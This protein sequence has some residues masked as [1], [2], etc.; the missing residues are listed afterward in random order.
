ML[1]GLN[2]QC[3]CSVLARQQ[4]RF[5][6]R[7]TRMESRQALFM[8]G[9]NCSAASFR[10]SAQKIGTTPLPGKLA[11]NECESF[12]CL[13]HCT[14]LRSAITKQPLCRRRSET[15]KKAVKQTVSLRWFPCF[16]IGVAT[17]HRKLTVCFTRARTLHVVGLCVHELIQNYSILD[18]AAA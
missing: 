8:S 9:T 18:R 13:P 11:W 3:T 2:H 15:Q 12:G 1:N 10:V 14:R 5:A 17:S 6:A 7:I 4:L 16:Q